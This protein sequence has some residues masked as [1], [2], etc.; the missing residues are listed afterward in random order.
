MY[1]AKAKR[2][3]L[4]FAFVIKALLTHSIPMPD[5]WFQTQ[6]FL[7]YALSLGRRGSRPWGQA[8]TSGLVLGYLLWVLAVLGLMSLSFWTYPTG[9]ALWRI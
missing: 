4:V 5:G 8:Q 3:D 2:I 1:A 7:K 6:P 9:S